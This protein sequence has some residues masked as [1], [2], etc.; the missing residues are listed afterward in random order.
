MQQSGHCLQ[1]PSHLPC[2]QP[3]CGVSHREGGREERELSLP[4]DDSTL[5]KGFGDSGEAK[6]SKDATEALEFCCL[7]QNA[8]ALFS[9]FDLG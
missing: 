9:I 2:K 6:S 4:V 7:V 5:P 1:E 3:G 8:E